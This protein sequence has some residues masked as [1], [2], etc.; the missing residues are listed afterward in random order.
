MNTAVL[1]I[2]TESDSLFHQRTSMLGS[3]P[4]AASR[5]RNTLISQVPSRRRMNVD[6]SRHQ[7]SRNT[8]VAGG[9]THGPLGT[10]KVSQRAK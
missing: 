4:K 9:I 3:A 10:K 8:Q 2:Q 7:T 6:V 1:E 5:A